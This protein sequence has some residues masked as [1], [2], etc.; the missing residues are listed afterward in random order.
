MTELVNFIGFFLALALVVDSIVWFRLVLE[1]E[2]GK[3]FNMACLMFIV[4]MDVIA[5]G[6]T[7]NIIKYYR[8]MIGAN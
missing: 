8:T 2:M 1:M 3:V 4:T 5:L 6:L 7:I